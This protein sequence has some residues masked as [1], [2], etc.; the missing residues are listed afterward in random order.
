MGEQTFERARLVPTSRGLYAHLALCNESARCA[1]RP[2]QRNAEKSSAYASRTESASILES[3][4][5][6]DTRT[7]V[8]GRRKD[9]TDCLTKRTAG[10]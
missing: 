10:P 3:T 2:E 9:L 1:R 4:T 7:E 6:N 8:K 5:R